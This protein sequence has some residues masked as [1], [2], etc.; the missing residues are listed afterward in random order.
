MYRRSGRLLASRLVPVVIGLIVLGL[1]GCDIQKTEPQHTGSLYITLSV[2]D[3]TADTLI[4]GAR[5]RVDGAQTIR[6][7]PAVISNLPIGSHT[8]S[9]YKPG[10]VDTSVTHEVRLNWTDTVAVQ[11]VRATDGA[12]NLVGAPDGT[13]LLI[14]NLPVDTVPVSTENPTL[15]QNIGVGTF[16]VSAYLPGHATELPAKWTIQV[17][18][19]GTVSLA[20][21]FVAAPEGVDIGD[22]APSFQLTSDW[23]S[24]YGLQEYRGKVCLVT[25]FFYDCSACMEEFP[26]IASMY[27]DPRYAGKLQ[28]LGVDFTDSYSR[29]SQF[30]A[31]HDA[32]GV[33]F[34]L[35][36][37]DPRQTVKNAYNIFA[38]P[39]NV[40]VDATGRVKLV[41]GGISEALLHQTVNDAL[42][43]ADAPTFS[44]AMRDTLITYTVRDQYYKFHGVTTNLLNA[45][46]TFIYQVE[47]VVYPDTSRQTSICTWFTCYR[48]QSG[49]FA[50]SESYSPMQ[51]DTGVGFIVY[52]MK[53]YWQDSVATL[54]TASFFGDYILDVTMYPVDN[55]GE[56]VT[57][58]LHLHDGNPSAPDRN[59]PRLGY[60]VS[61]FDVPTNR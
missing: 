13:V 33:T 5:I 61:P 50:Q 49:A 9:V 17:S 7:T 40:I 42:E 25:F 16:E 28:F 32:L 26:Y 39:A 57:N 24:S 30:R 11:T 55:T 27:R 2:G 38:C 15:F 44:F 22:L 53:N 60:A 47:P 45:P 51:V 1:A 35:L 12:I 41:Q 10:F 8:I 48:S 4:S 29:F 37:D 20:P 19:G 6:L 46:R 58:R 43:A 36:H 59:N 52:N 56:R 54:D 23:G 34:P 31:D 21:V 3:S 14:N 18:P